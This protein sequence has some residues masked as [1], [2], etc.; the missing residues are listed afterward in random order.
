MEG[1][2]EQV[3]EQVEGQVEQVEEQVEQVQGASGGASGP[4]LSTIFFSNNK[5]RE[6]P[7]NSAGCHEPTACF[8][9]PCLTPSM[10][11]PLYSY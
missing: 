8:V 11:L 9:T 3:E 5:C 4:S 2:V 6:E 7:Q 1:Q 10:P